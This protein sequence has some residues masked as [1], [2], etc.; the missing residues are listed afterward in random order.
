MDKAYWDGLAGCYARKVFDVLGQDRR[1][2]ICSRIAR[3][4]GAGKSA[5]DAGCGTG[6]F[7]PILCR[8]FSKVIAIDVSHGLLQK[9]RRRCRAHSNV[10]FLRADLSRGGTE[11]PAVDLVVCVNCL[12]TPSAPRRTRMLSAMR[13]H[14]KSGGHLLLVVPSLESALYSGFRLVEWNRKDGMTPSQAV[15]AGWGRDGK[16]LSL[17]V[18]QGLVALDGVWTKHFLKEELEVTAADLN[19]DL[20]E[21]VK[22]EYGWNTEFNRPPRW[23]G[24]PL[25]WD[26]LVVATRS[27]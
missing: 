18:G 20:V 16:S 12:I 3:L 22:V 25:P 17:R 26:W 8:C 21:I 23:L 15:R 5:A 19:L 27:T 10:R 6:R 7:L 4:G 13:A 1:E 14:M 9:A 2:T 11:W 24:S